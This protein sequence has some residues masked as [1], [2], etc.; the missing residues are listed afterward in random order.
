[1]KTKIELYFM[2]LG[3]LFVLLLIKV[4]N[5]P[6]C[7]DKGAC[8]IGWSEFLKTNILTIFFLLC[9]IAEYVCFKRF[10]H[11]LEGARDIPCKIKNI[12][13]GNFEYLTFLTTYIIPLVCFDLEKPNEFVLLIVLLILLGILFIKTNLYYTN[14][15][16]CILGFNIYEADI[17]Y[18]G[19]EVLGI[20]ILSK[21]KLKK[22]DIFKKIDLV[23]NEI[24]YCK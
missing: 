19:K 10:L 9:L 11:S 2:S 12:R 1:M 8:F 7:F 20:K 21:N 23:F 18:K 15:S 16:L 5:I 22:N 13:N 14:P 3:L 17:E 24:I 6:V 4:I